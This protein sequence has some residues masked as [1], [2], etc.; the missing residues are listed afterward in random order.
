M[1]RGDLRSNWTRGFSIT[2]CQHLRSRSPVTFLFRPP[3]RL[4]VGF[5]IPLFSPL[6]LGGIVS[7]PQNAQKDRHE[8]GEEQ[9]QE[10]PT[11]FEPGTRQ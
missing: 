4:G 1:R 6:L 2:R 8:D 7:S 10:A 3:Q 5:F 11:A 9:K